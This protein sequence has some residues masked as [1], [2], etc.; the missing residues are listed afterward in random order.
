MK[1]TTLPDHH[2]FIIVVLVNYHIVILWHGI[3]KQHKN[4]TWSVSIKSL[5]KNLRSPH[6]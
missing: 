2:G 3:I 4:S 1:T 6:L 5:I